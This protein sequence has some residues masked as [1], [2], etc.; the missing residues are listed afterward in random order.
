M[1]FAGTGFDLLSPE[2]VELFLLLGVAHH[3]PVVLEHYGQKSFGGSGSQYRSL[4][5][6]LLCQIGQRSTVV[7]VEVSDDNQVHSIIDGF[8]WRVQLSEVGIAPVVGEE[9]V[10]ADIEHDGF[11]MKGDADTRAAYLLSC[12]QAE[13]LYWLCR[14]CSLHYLLLFT[15]FRAGSASNQQQSRSIGSAQLELN[16]VYSYRQN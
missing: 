11:I 13:H 2:G 6:V 14:L 5:L 8:W 12:S 16:S 4:V 3:F 10:N 15:I 9:H 7:K 1:H